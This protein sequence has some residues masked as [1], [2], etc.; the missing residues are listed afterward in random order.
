MAFDKVAYQRE[1]MRR[2]RAAENT[3]KPAESSESFL[4][5]QG[6]L[7]AALAEIAVLRRER[8]ALVA[9]IN[10]AEAAPA[11]E[12]AAARKA[13]KDEAL[14]GADEVAKAEIERLTKLNASLRIKVKQTENEYY[15]L[16]DRRIP[17][18]KQEFRKIVAAL[19]PD[20]GGNAEV[21]HTFNSKRDLL[22]RPSR[23]SE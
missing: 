20:K 15:A 7:N 3:Q 18:S 9:R 11:K 23:P 10:A 5:L 22:E 17:F 6:R 13:E 12:S 14:A 1:Y 19:H 2:R 21:F 4:A 16:A 8:E